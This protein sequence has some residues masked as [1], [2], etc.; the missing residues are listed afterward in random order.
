M[1]PLVPIVAGLAAFFGLGTLGWYYTLSEAEQRKADAMANYYAGEIYGVA[2][3]QLTA[4]Q[5]R[6]I[7]SMVARHFN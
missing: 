1:I 2:V 6:H 5:A 7:S 3:D 4:E